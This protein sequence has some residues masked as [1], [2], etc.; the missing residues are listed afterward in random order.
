[1]ADASDNHYWLTNGSAGYLTTDGTHPV[2]A[3]HALIA[4]VM[5]GALVAMVP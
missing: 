5:R 3:G 2:G 1:V 4:P